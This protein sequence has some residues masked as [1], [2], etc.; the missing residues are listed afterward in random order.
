MDIIT[1]DSFIQ[2]GIVKDI[3]G[4]LIGNSSRS[5]GFGG[6]CPGAGS[7]ESLPWLELIRDLDTLSSSHATVYVPLLDNDVELSEDSR[8]DSLD[9]LYGNITDEGLSRL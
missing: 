2:L 8:P 7:D 5:G 3:I 9:I 6:G 1:C 4:Y